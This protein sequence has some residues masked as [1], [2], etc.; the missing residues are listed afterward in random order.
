M[1]I[2]SILALGVA[3]ILLLAGCGGGGGGGAPTFALGG[4]VA[5]LA[6]GGQL[7][8]LSGAGTQATLAANGNFR[9][10]DRLAQGSKYSLS[11][12]QQPAGQTCTVSNGSDTVGIKA[13]T[14]NIT[15]VCADNPA[16]LGGTVS[17]LHTGTSVTITN[18]GQS[19]VTVSANGPYALPVRPAPGTAYSVTVA[20]QPQGASC[21]VSNG[22]GTAASE[23]VSNIDV[24]CSLARVAIGGDVVGLA[25]GQQVKLKLS[26]SGVPLTDPGIALTVNG[27]F[28]FGST[29]NYGGDYLVAVDTQPTGQT[30]TLSNASGT[31]VTMAVTQ[32]RVSCALNRHAL[33]GSATG[34]VLVGGGQPLVLRNGSDSVVVSANGP[35]RFP[36]LLADGTGYSVTVGSQ[37]TG[38]TCS[39]SNDSAVTVSGP[40]SNV[41][42]QC[43]SFVWRTRLIAGSGLAG[44]MDGVAA[45]ARFSAPSAVALG[46]SGDLFV[47]DFSSSRIRAVTMPFGAVST[48]AGT[49]VPGFINNSVPLLASFRA[50][51]GVAVDAAGNVF[52]A[53]SGNHVIRRIAA[54]SGEV[55][56]WAGSGVAG[57]ANG[58]GPAA[59]FNTPR[60]LAIDAS[61]ILYVADTGNHVIR[62][63]A[64]VAANGA[65]AAAGA[66]SLWAGTPGVRGRADGASATFN[67]PSGL[68][69]A[70]QGSVY[71][72]DTQN[73]LIRVVAPGGVV[74]TV[75][76]SGTS[77]SQDGTGPLA[78]FSLPMAV[79]VDA[80]ANLFVADAG[81]HTLRQVQLVGGVGTVL[82][83]AGS[84]SNGYRE[85]VGTA[86][87]F[88]QPT[89]LALD[90][91]G[92]LLVTEGGGH[93]IRSVYRS[94]N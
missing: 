59:Q 61:G 17:G 93:R 94:A 13:D 82:T 67:G 70:P 62:R 74:G 22:S 2:Q 68:A 11:V 72:A 3:S 45:S 77:G 69:V 40:V 65:N 64:P 50:P 8:L 29:I 38:Q 76:G 26:G 15:V 80:Q 85:G 78:S 42:A 46:P 27:S 53:D 52:V 35:F 1:M 90:S 47:A 63:I 32:L 79:V 56:T 54:G 92:N 39:V 16:V 9:F 66:V 55:T 86:A 7:V 60:G 28:S 71:V 4:T 31:G 36:S 87:V 91:G 10:P 6:S 24:V 5:G 12:H 37:P 30:C 14:T 20:S 73:H 51:A 34:L 33:S 43:L 75:A 88:D 41:V 25:S 19:T 49:T 57:Y 84:G 58:T 48:M 23:R 18:G 81:N 44:A 89:G 21:A 83:I